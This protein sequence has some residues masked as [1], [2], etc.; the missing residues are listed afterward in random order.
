MTTL[1]TKCDYKN[2]IVHRDEGVAKAI[3][4]FIDASLCWDDIPWFRS[5]TN[6][7]IILKG[8]GCSLDKVM[9]C[10]A[11]CAGVV[12]SNHGERQLDTA[13]SAIEELPEAIEDLHHERE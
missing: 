10:K 13:R 9:D 12:L 2:E 3:S 8:V 5:I 4:A 6:L 11:G 1:C 7:P